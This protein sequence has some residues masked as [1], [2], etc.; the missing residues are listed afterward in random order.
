MA[1]Y[2]PL[3]SIGDIVWCKFPESEA[4]GKPGPTPR[5]SL[6]LNI[7]PDQHAVLVAFGTSQKIH[8][9]FTGEF[10]IQDD[11]ATAGLS[12]PTKFDLNRLQ[13]LPFNT[14][15]FDAAP[16]T[17]RNTPAPKL[18]V[19]PPVCM[20]PMREAWKALKAKKSAG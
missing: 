13:I 17:P 2:N 16:V 3:P 11:L 9:V 19:L 8:R 12:Y 4:L 18:G 6:I 7:M 5:P 15:W 1:H 10:V 14:D 20:I